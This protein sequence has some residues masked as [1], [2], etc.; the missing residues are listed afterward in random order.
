MIH[1]DFKILIFFNSMITTIYNSKF[2]HHY[3]VQVMSNNIAFV[4]YCTYVNDSIAF[5]ISDIIVN[6][7]RKI[8]FIFKF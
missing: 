8:N 1:I 7:A 3:L 6:L 4:F 5:I 2:V